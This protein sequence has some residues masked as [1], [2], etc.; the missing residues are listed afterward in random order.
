MKQLIA[1]LTGLHL[2]AHGVFGCCDHGLLKQSQL[3]SEC[4]CHGGIHHADD[5]AKSGNC[6]GLDH[7][8]PMP[9]SHHCLHDACHWVAD[10]DGPCVASLDFAA[11]VFVAFVPSPLLTVL[12]P[13]EFQP[14][15]I[16]GR[17][18]TPPLRLHLVLGMLLI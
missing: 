15:D 6:N 11:P 10:S 7:D 1:I 12:H 13:A 16:L 17:T 14:D 4:A 18:S 9:G 3:E 8:L 5:V 2:L